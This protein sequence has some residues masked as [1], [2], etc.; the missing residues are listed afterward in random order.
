MTNTRE[1]ILESANKWIKIASALQEVET[2]ELFLIK[3]LRDEVV[4]LRGV[5]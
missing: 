4:R 3:K 5:Q 2:V 1:D